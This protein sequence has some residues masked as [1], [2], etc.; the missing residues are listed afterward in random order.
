[1]IPAVA[2]ADVAGI[3]IA[4]GLDETALGSPA[5]E[6]TTRSPLKMAAALFAFTGYSRND[7]VKL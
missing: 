7:P 2:S 5:V 1:M 3:L 6:S 4:V